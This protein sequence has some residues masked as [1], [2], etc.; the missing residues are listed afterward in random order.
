MT[1]TSNCF[2]RRTNCMPQRVGKLV[3]KFDAGIFARVQARDDFVP[4]DARFHHIALVGGR[5]LV[6]ALSRELERD[7]PDP[8]DLMG[9]RRPVCRCRVSGRCQGR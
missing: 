5:H 2:G 7:T 3:L 9:R 6:A 1:M 8:L 4:E